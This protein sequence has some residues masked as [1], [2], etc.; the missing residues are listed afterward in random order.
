MGSLTQFL[1]LSNTAS[2]KM[3]P[4]KIYGIFLIWENLES[5]VE[6][7]MGNDFLS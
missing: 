7:M 5:R 3:K 2:V 4:W 6:E 1:D